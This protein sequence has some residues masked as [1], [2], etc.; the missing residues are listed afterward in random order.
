MKNLVMSHKYI[1]LCEA[2]KSGFYIVVGDEV[3][4]FTTAELLGFIPLFVADNGLNELSVL[5]KFT[6]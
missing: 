3:S 1:E 5:K 2:W 6:T 4:K